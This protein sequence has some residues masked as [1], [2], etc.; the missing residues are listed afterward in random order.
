MK[1]PACA[2]CLIVLLFIG[3]CG[4]AEFDSQLAAAA[5]ELERTVG[6]KPFPEWKS[7][8]G[9]LVRV[10]F[11]FETDDVEKLTIGDLERHV[12]AAVAKHVHPPPQSVGVSTKRGIKMIVR[13]NTAFEL[14]VKQRGPRLAAARA[15]WP[16]AQLDR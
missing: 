16:A 4:F 2:I 6:S 7:Q 10:T 13:P 5:N 15:P 3:A 14:S 9:V 11:I 12:Q 8:N 1:R